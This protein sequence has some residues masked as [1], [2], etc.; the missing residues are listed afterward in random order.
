[1]RKKEELEQKLQHLTYHLSEKGISG[2]VINDFL[3]SMGVSPRF[4]GT[5]YYAKLK[6]NDLK[7]GLAYFKSKNKKECLTLIVNTGGHWVTI[8][9]TNS[10]IYYINSTGGPIDRKPLH[11]ALVQTAQMGNKTLLRNLVKVQ[12]DSSNYCGLYACLWVLYLDKK[13][14]GKIKFD[15]VNL[16]RNDKKCYQYLQQAIKQYKE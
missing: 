11:D 2:R 13:F 9:S 7:R 3:F 16:E 6:G 4:G 12:A 14:K 8:A 5:L 1:M 15:R 10:T